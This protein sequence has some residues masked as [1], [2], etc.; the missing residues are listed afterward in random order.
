[1]S[2]S[3]HITGGGIR[4]TFSAACIDSLQKHGGPWMDDLRRVSGVSAGSIVAACLASKKDLAHAVDVLQAR[5]FIEYRSTCSAAAHALTSWR[6]GTAYYSNHKMLEALH[7]ITS[8]ATC[9]VPE[10]II[11]VTNNKTMQQEMRTVNRGS[12]IDAREILAS[13]SIPALF[14]PV[15]LGSTQYVDGGVFS[16]F[17]RDAVMRDLDDHATK[18]SLMISSQPWEHTRSAEG[19]PGIRSIVTEFVQ[20]LLWAQRQQCVRQYI[21]KL[22]GSMD[23]MPPRFAILCRNGTAAA[24]VLP[25]GQPPACAWDKAVIFC[26]PEEHEFLEWCSTNLTMRPHDRLDG[27]QAMRRSGQAAA[28]DVQRLLLLCGLRNIDVTA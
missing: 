14:P 25:Q 26:S 2:T 12:A 16:L 7:D 21:H 15:Q 4:G 24:T 23:Y 13:C 19:S 3:I 18:V 17:A 28:M 27:V 22:G 11:G 6:H 10:L 20:S 9:Q 1:M 5:D 8:N